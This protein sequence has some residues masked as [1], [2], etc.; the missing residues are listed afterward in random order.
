MNEF[1]ENH[2]ENNHSNSKM[3]QNIK[4]R[5]G[6]FSVSIFLIQACGPEKDKTTTTE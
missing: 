3:L 4:N 1:L 2:S 5:L 6:L